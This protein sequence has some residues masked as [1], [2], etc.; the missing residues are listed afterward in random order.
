[1]SK[2]FAALVCLMMVSGAQAQS[3]KQKKAMAADAEKAKEEVA[4]IQKVCGCA[5]KFTVNYAE[6]TTDED[7]LIPSRTRGQV[8]SALEN[9]CKDA[10]GK[11]AVC[12]KL[13]EVVVKKGEPKPS[14]FKGTTLTVTRLRDT[15]QG[16]IETI[17]E[18]NL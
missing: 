1:M 16:D 15:S 6:L 17:L 9:L 2:L 10:E 11:K 4:E 5:P 8:K 3:L 14:T 12:A 18:N 7:Q 13:K